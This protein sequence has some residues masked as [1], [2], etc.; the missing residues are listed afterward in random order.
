[1]KSD[2]EKKREI[3]YEENRKELFW[4]L[5]N[6]FRYQEKLWT[7]SKLASFYE[8]KIFFSYVNSIDNS[9]LRAKAKAKAKAK[10]KKKRK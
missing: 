2:K 3:A 9:E 4:L 5:K 8:H 7:S 6:S 10:R 1:M